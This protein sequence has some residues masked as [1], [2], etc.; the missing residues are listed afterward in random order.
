MSPSNSKYW[1]IH[2]CNI[3][4]NACLIFKTIIL[5]P[6]FNYRQSSISNHLLP[7]IY[8]EDCLHFD[9]LRSPEFGGTLDLVP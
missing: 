5:Y 4:L 7:L 1:K 9:Y 3:T 8:F 6:F 2:F